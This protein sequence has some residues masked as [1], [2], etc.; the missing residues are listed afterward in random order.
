M[1]KSMR[2][3]VVVAPNWLG[4]VIMALPALADIRRYYPDATLHVAARASVSSIY[5]LVPGVDATITLPGRGGWSTL[6]TLRAQAEALAGGDYE[7]AIL[8]P[9][10][11]ASALVVLRAGIPERWGFATDA[12]ARL[13]TRAIPRPCLATHQA[14]YYQAL[15]SALDIPSG[16]LQP[17]VEVREEQRAAARSLLDTCGLRPQTRAVV[18]APG[19]AYGRAKQWVPE[20]FAELA[21]MLSAEGISPVLVGTAA[22]RVVCA[23]IAALMRQ[24][25][26][27]KL[28][29]GLAVEAK[30]SPLATAATIDLCGQTTLPTL[31]GVLALAG[32][33][34]SNDSGAMHLAAAVGAHVVAVFGATDERRTAPLANGPD[35]PVPRLVSAHVE[36]RPCM[37]RE[38]PIDHR[39]MT[40][41]SAQQ[42]R[43]ALG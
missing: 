21:T 10:S 30:A 9:N 18:L 24:G 5:A 13:L 37:L 26:F 19:A 31:A 27:D 6:L 8:L 39:C 7:A 15:T 1:G 4:D 28:R 29:A 25:S 35:A 40:R 38:C 22:D 33:C 11:F 34:V 32:S 3:L 42:V 17:L 20:R 23:E 36:C 41:V 2:R 14:A 43:D 16:P 12:R